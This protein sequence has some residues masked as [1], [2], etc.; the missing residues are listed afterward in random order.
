MAWHP[1]KR[2][3]DP[4]EQRDQDGGNSPRRLDMRG[5]ERLYLLLSG[6]IAKPSS[7]LEWSA[8]EA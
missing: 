1:K 5:I 3:A 2:Q 4:R 8:A 7:L 6:L